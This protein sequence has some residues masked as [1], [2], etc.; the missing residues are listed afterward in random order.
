MRR[1]CADRLLITSERHLRKVLGEYEQHY[2]QHRPHRSRDRQPP[3]ALSPAVATAKLG[4][5]QLKREKVLSGLINQ[6]ARA[7]M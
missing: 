3:Q 6:Y 5:V 7:A 1:E 4:R 2:N